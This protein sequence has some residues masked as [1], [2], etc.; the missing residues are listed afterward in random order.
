MPLG[1]TKDSMLNLAEM[2]EKKE[3][4]ERA[5]S[6]GDDASAVSQTNSKQQQQ[7]QQSTTTTRKS[8]VFSS[9]EEQVMQVDTGEIKTKE[10]AR[11]SILLDDSALLVLDHQHSVTSSS[12]GGG[13][14]GMAR[15]SMVH[16]SSAPI[17]LD[18][19]LNNL[20]MELELEH[21]NNGG[22]GVTP[23]PYGSTTVAS[24][25]GSAGSG[26]GG[27]GNGDSINSAA[28]DHRNH[29]PPQKI[30]EQQQQQY[31]GFSADYPDY[32][33]YNYHST[34]GAP[35]L[36]KDHEANNKE[37]QSFW[38]CLFPW[39]NH[40][41]PDLDFL[42]NDDEI[43]MLNT[44]A[45]HES[46]VS[47]GDGLKDL[48]TNT[49]MPTRVGGG[50]SKDDDEL[51]STGSDVFGEKLS[52]KDRQAVLA[53]LGLC[54][55]DPPPVAETPEQ[56]PT[57]QKGKG[58][59]NGITIP[60]ANH[61]G[62]RKG[63]LKRSSVSLNQQL[64]DDRPS[65]QTSLNGTTTGSN[66]STV[67]NNNKAPKRRSLFPQYE[68]SN[69]LK[70]NLTARFA[71]MARVV[72]VKSKN[73]MSEKEK[74]DVWWQKSD[75]EEFRKTGRMITRAM[76]EGGSEIW[77][78]SNQSWLQP[79]Q[80]RAS[81]LKSA[82][83]MSGRHQAMNKSQKAAYEKARD[84]WWHKFGH[85]RRGLEHIASMDEGRQRQQN[86]R[87][88]IRAVIEEQRRQKVFHREDSEKLRMAS[89]SLSAWARDLSMAAGASDADAVRANFD[90]DGRKS[91]EFYLLKFARANTTG[92]TAPTSKGGM[93]NV[94]AFM[95]PILALKNNRYDANTVSQIRFRQKE[96]KSAAAAKSQVVP[97]KETPPAREE[98]VKN[99]PEEDDDD[100][101]CE[102]EEETRDPSERRGD[103]ARRA[104]GYASGE[105]IGNMSA[106]LSGM[107]AGIAA[108]GGP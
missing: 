22:G 54:Q 99:G 59:L 65:S 44:S 73:D 81:T 35:A 42:E 69:K 61:S 14:G 43:H 101:Q 15:D 27:S 76:L 10:Q 41:G 58:L 45:S 31:A 97:K 13:M 48:R 67:E 36:L 108:V 83:T 26:G 89:I 79:N 96:K 107:G 1:L 55:P 33:N 60:V 75:Y 80:S 52:D 23:T 40:S 4:E 68:T 30:I 77:L 21:E 74:G 102:R 47:V 98:P 19:D 93:N 39:L 72:T 71:S 104:A 8:Q 25:N 20:E 11:A 24:S 85:S 2:A 82:Y 37:N 51:S 28:S 49:N 92:G 88:A 18:L 12:A 100:G 64:G 17:P 91:R 95:Q 94:P 53:R 86:V 50:S 105:E 46:L 29:K 6:E 5:A 103:L 34:Y 38:C 78:A 3:E 63:I 62:R 87:T 7:Q 70:K 9:D 56:P 106:V 84:K 16:L 66:N 57:T 32:Q 90:E